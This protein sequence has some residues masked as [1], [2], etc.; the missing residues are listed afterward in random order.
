MYSIEEKQRAIETYIANHYNAGKTVKELG[1]PSSVA[2][3]NWYRDYN[4]PKKL[5]P[6]RKIRKYSEEE[7]QKAID[8]YLKNSCNV[9]KTVREL[10]YGS[11]TGLLRWCRERVPEK[12][13]KVVPRKWEMSHS[14]DEK[15]RAVIELCSDSYSCREL[16]EKYGISKATLYEWKIQYIGKGKT[17][18]KED[19]ESLD[20]NEASEIRCLKEE[21]EAV[22]KELSETKKNLY[23]AQLEHDVYKKAAEILK[24]EMGDN[25]K[26]F[27]NREKA[28]VIEALR[29]KYP[30]KDILK[31][32]D[33]AKSSYCYQHNQLQKEDKFIRLRERITEIYH[34]N[35]G[36]YGYRRIHAVL[37][38]EGIKISEKTVRRIMREE[39]LKV[40]S[41]RQRK[42]NSYMGEISPA[43]PNVIERKFHADKPNEKWLTDITEFKF[44]DKKVYLSPIIDCFDGMPVAWTVGES[45]NA[46]LVNTMLDQA[47]AQLKSKEKPV[48]HSDRGCHYRWPG[49]IE[50]MEQA[51]LTRSMSKKGCSPDNSAC[52][53]FFGRM[54]NEMFYGYNWN[55]VSSTEFIDIVNE[56]MVWYREKRIKISLGGKSPMNYRR[57]LGLA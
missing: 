17:V 28:M 13:S 34:E 38:T 41:I 22:K 53:G 37:K 7:K 18:L 24:K 29:F 33:M 30:V 52:E 57:E 23:Q 46:E 35:K 36:R 56:Y 42:Y 54:K 5:K 1:Y 14:E 11:E 32:F 19:K 27:S 15:R 40:R 2:L 21:L 44:G 3:I 10:G 43:V 4:P 26:D 51:G 49:W 48:V 6:T 12:A 55:H 8:L 9:K 20:V 31:V 45:P 16:C 39:H 50:R 47:I 25:L